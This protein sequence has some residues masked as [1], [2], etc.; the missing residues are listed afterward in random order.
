MTRRRLFVLTGCCLVSGLAIPDRAEAA[1]LKAYVKQVVTRSKQVPTERRK[2]LDAIAAGIRKQLNSK[3]VAAVTFV[4]THNSRRSQFSQAWAHT[5]ARHFGIKGLTFHS[6]GTEATAANPRTIK[7]LR[8][9]GFSIKGAGFMN[10][11]YTVGG[12]EA[13]ESFRLYSKVFWSKENPQ[14]DFIAV[15]CCGDADKKCPVVK[16]A[17]ARFSLHYVDPKVS[18]GTS[19]ESATYD[20]RCR[21]IAAEMFYLIAQLKQR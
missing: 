21:Q 4:C 2:A 9:A 12:L 16:G 1:N 17:G 20:D 11:T 14:K 5:A 19:K 18:D 13:G 10:P 8:R 3:G 6:G 15:I 7:A